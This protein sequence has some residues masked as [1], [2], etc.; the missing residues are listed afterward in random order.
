M[1]RRHKEFLHQTDHKFVCDICQKT[2]PF[3]YVMNRHRKSHTEMP[4]YVQCQVCEKSFRNISYMKKHQKIHV[5]SYVDVRNEECHKCQKKFRTKKDL[6][7]HAIIHTNLK[8]FSCE[9]CGASFNNTGTL[10]RHKRTVI[11]QKE[12]R[13]F[14][15][16]CPFRTDS[17]QK[18]ESHMMNKTS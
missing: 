1:L 15:D 10:H 7:V 18:L 9:D 16:K 3:K 14:C 6:R 17:K 11:H 5:P 2:F 8:P 4:T 12:A 13:Y